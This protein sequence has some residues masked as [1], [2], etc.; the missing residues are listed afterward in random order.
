[1]S[2][3]IKQVDKPIRVCDLCGE[4]TED[5]NW[6]GSFQLTNVYKDERPLKKKWYHALMWAYNGNPTYDVHHTCLY[7]LLKQTLESKSDVQ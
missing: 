4:P 1:M 2:Q 3:V 6:L 5:E 7:Q